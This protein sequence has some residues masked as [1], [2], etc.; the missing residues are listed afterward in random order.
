[1]E[2]TAKEKEGVLALVLLEQQV[3]LFMGE[4]SLV[5]DLTRLF[6]PLSL[7]P[8]LFRFRPPF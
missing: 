1:M 2:K 8:T 6:P 7:L 3:G 4:G 5:T